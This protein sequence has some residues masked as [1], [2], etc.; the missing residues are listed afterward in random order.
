MLYKL[1]L[2][3]QE[4]KRKINEVNFLYCLNQGLKW[5]W[6]RLIF[7]ATIRLLQANLG[8]EDSKQFW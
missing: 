4:E 7:K 2:S 5:I 8:F 6:G 1:D 3:V